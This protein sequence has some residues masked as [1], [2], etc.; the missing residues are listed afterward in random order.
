MEHYPQRQNFGP[1]ETKSRYPQ[2]KFTGKRT[3]F[4]NS[5]ERFGPN[6]NK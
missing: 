6:S 3:R 5:V 2:S 1:L 4:G